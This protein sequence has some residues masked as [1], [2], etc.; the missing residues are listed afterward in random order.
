MTS[1]A[2]PSPTTASTLTPTRRTVLGAA[3]WTVPAITVAGA[4]PAYAASRCVTTSHTVS[5]S[6]AMWTPDATNQNATRGTIPAV[7]GTPGA[8]AVTLTVTRQFFGNMVAAAQNPLM[9]MQISSDTVGGTGARGLTLL[10]QQNQSTANPGAGQN[11]HD[12]RQTVT[13]TF[14]EEVKNL[15]FSVTDV[16]NYWQGTNP[17]NSRQYRDRVYVSGAPTATTS[18]LGSGTQSD[19]WHRPDSLGAVDNATSGEGNVTLDYGS[20]ALQQVQMTFFNG[21]NRPLVSNGIHAVFISSM[22]FDVETCA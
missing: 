15:R 9:N 10:Q 20:T 11:V 1:P 5:W 13:F 21:Y 12:H 4:A 14:S 18:L 7:S 2:A 17:A 16:D 19:P 3:A 8:P 6:A 22:T